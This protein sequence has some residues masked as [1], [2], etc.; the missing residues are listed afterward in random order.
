MLNI[1]SLLLAHFLHIRTTAQLNY[2]EHLQPDYF[3]FIS[4]LA[5]MIIILLLT[6]NTVSMFKPLVHKIIL[7][8][9]LK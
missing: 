2:C 1:L 4:E 8:L 6:S 9:T 5:K 7:F 3:L